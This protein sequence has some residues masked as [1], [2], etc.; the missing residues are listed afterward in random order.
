MDSINVLAWGW[1]Y[2]GNVIS[3]EWIV[4]ALAITYI[5]DSVKSSS[6]QCLSLCM[7]NEAKS[8]LWQWHLIFIIVFDCHQVV[9]FTHEIPMWKYLH[10]SY[11]ICQCIVSKRLKL[12]LSLPNTCLNC[13]FCWHK[14]Y[15]IRKPEEN[16]N[17]CFCLQLMVNRPGFMSLPANEL[18][19]ALLLSAIKCL[20]TYQ[21]PGIKQAKKIQHSC[22]KLM[23]IIQNYW[24]IKTKP[25]I[26]YM[27]EIEIYF[28]QIA[29]CISFFQSTLK[30]HVNNLCM[31]RC[32]C[33]S[34]I[35][36]TWL[37]S[38]E[39]LKD[40]SSIPSGWALNMLVNRWSLFW[41]S[42]SEALNNMSLCK[43]RLLRLCTC[44]ALSLHL[45]LSCLY[46]CLLLQFYLSPFVSSLLFSCISV[47]WCFIKQLFFQF[48]NDEWK[49]RHIKFTNIHTVQIFYC[50]SLKYWIQ[51]L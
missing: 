49:F 50:K 34:F 6:L 23:L 24:S 9:G 17:A 12:V 33:V 22:V 25:Q 15:I 46:H 8:I 19:L 26:R 41:V 13:N 16:I 39:L 32:C 20:L 47:I 28:C 36:P 27:S 7:T 31:Q 14:I 30:A 2:T 45:P 18:F 48:C 1:P 35:F 11:L 5:M 38:W 51:L 40:G 21:A 37:S 43:R 3:Q 10:I 4:M 29:I 44:S 42:A